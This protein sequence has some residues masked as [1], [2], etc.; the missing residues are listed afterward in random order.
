MLHCTICTVPK[1]LD[2]TKQETDQQRIFQ[3]LLLICYNKSVSSRDFLKL[4]FQ[5]C[6][7]GMVDGACD[8]I[9]GL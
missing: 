6:L 8:S 9:S 5:G 3:M 7:G 1:L 4:S 2:N